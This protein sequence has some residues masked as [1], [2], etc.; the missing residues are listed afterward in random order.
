MF[1][2]VYVHCQLDVLIARDTKGLYAKALRGEIAHFT[3]I[4]DPYEPPL[5]PELVIDS[6]SETPEQSAAR[7]WDKLKA[8]G[9]I[10]HE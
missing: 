3:G 2:E 10:D 8:L 9:V 5:H 1:V 4:S 6:S 7:V